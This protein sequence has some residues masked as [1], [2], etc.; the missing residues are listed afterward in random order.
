MKALP[1]SKLKS[2][3]PFETEYISGCAMLIKKEVFREAGLL[4]EI[5]FLY[6]E[7]ADFC[8]RAGRK[9]FRSL[10]VPHSRAYHFEKSE[11]DKSSKIYWLVI[12]GILFFRKNTPSLLKPWMYFYL[13]LRKMKNRRD[14]KDEKNEIAKVVQKAYKDLKNGK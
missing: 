8:F 10:V 7:D 4:D 13:L 5:F 9:G 11:F 6:Y 1:N 14:L 2:K 3:E 12:S